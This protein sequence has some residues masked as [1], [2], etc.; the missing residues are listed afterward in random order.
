MK[1]FNDEIVYVVGGSMGIGFAAA[2]LFAERG[3]H[4]CVFARNQ[5][6]LKNAEKRV[7][8]RAK[9]AG[10]R[11]ASYPVDVVDRK[12]VDRVMKR[13]LKEFGTP[14][15]LVNCAGQATPR[16]FVEMAYEQFDETMK[17]NLYGTRNTIAALLP[18]MKARGCGAIVNTSSIAGY[19]G[20]F[21]YTDYNASKFAVLGFSEALRCEL[22][23]YGIELF[24]LCPPDTDTPGLVVEN[25]TKPPETKALTAKAK[26][27]TP[28]AVA[29]AMIRGMEKGKFIILPGFDGKF[30]VLAQRFIP[31]VV[32][33]VVDGTVRKVQKNR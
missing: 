19:V 23:G 28:E 20:V 24:V 27:M 11:F 26:L 16:I 22:V 8:G 6:R 9:S 14:A 30:T 29:A 5:E 7:A 4:V 31:G 3:A 10:Q 1:D 18:A 2:K 15:V 12:E 32:R 25:Q 21:G 17:I 33:W 13:A